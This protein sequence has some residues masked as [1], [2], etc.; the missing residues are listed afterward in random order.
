MDSKKGLWVWHK[1]LRAAILGGGGGKCEHSPLSCVSS[2]LPFGLQLATRRILQRPGSPLCLSAQLL[3]CSQT[4]AHPEHTWGWGRWGS[5]HTE[6]Q[7]L[8]TL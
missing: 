1:G 3:S 5:P 4:L 6:Q 8:T 2:C 7:G